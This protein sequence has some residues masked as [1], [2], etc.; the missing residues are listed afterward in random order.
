M[1]FLNDMDYHAASANNNISLM[2]V[3]SPRVIV[4]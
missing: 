4:H 1:K 3:V 2:H